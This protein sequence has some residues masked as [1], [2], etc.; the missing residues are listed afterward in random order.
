MLLFVIEPD[1]VQ[2]RDSLQRILWRRLEKFHDRRI[3]MA[4]IG[5]DLLVAGAGD[6]TPL[7]AGMAR[8][9][10]DII[11]VEQEGVIGVKRHVARAMLAEQK[12]LEVPGRMGAMPFSR[13]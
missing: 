9:S 2:R 11:G 4:V 12:L 5:A 6:V 7:M 8:T 1:L 10:A 3:D 13:A